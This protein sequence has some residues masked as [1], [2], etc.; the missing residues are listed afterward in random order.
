MTENPLRKSHDE[1]TL[2]YLQK[3][4]ELYKNASTDLKLQAWCREMSARDVV[5][6]SNYFGS[7]Y[8]PRVKNPIQPFVLFD[9][10]EEALNW[11]E[12]RYQQGE[13][14]IFEKSRYIG[15]SNV[16]CLYLAHKL[17]F[18]PNFQG[19][20]AS[21]KADFVD[22]QGSQDALFEKILFIINNLPKWMQPKKRIYRKHMLIVNNDNRSR[23]TGE[24]GD[25][26]GRASRSSVMF[27]DEAAFLERPDKVIASLSENTDTAILVSTPN[28]MNRFGKMRY[29]GNFPVF[30]YHWK[31]DPR[32]SQ[33]WYNEQK[34][35]LPEFV[36]KQELDIDY[37]GSVEG[38]LIKPEW[39]RSAVELVDKHPGM[40][41]IGKKIAGYDVAGEGSNLNVLI[42][43][44]GT[45]ITSIDSWKNLDVTQSAFRVVDI[46]NDKVSICHFDADGLGAGTAGTFAS[47]ES[48][49]FEF[50]PVHGGSRPSETL[51]E[52]ENRTSQQKFTNLRTEMWCLL[53]NRFRKTH[54]FVS[55]IQEYSV[56]ELISIPNHTDLISQL[57]TP[58]C[59]M[60]STGKL[61]LEGKDK[62]KARGISSPDYGDALALAFTP[63]NDS[64]KNIIDYFSL[65]S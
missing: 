45:V 34:K 47:V 50:N 54:E 2:W 60:T 41:N 35:K 58:T 4:F 13:W 49:P 40:Q 11:I 64:A 28:G 12:K 1:K 6:F 44:Q 63:E 53:A 33:E 21:R 10:Q 25:D 56:E 55:G 8:N 65:M 30:T 18:T 61:A 3:R 31:D 19:A 38:I 17:L 39:I 15:A 22:K 29:S 24:T 32:R 36:V 46:L 59:Q 62:M 26:I 48:L 23:I 43:R 5:W 51:W 57:S 27:L 9:K 14:A 20:I 7:T 42:Q 37:S 16:S 52:A